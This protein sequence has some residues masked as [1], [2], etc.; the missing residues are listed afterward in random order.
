[1][2]MG[3]ARLTAD[4]ALRNKLLDG[5][6]EKFER[7]ARAVPNAASTF[8]MWGAALVERGKLTGIRND[9]REGIDRLNTSVSLDPNNP[10]TLYSLAGAYAMMEKKL[11]AVQALKK[12]FEVDLNHQFYRLAPTD[13]DLAGLRDVPQ[14]SDLFSAGTRPDP[15]IYPSPPRD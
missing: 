3:A 15:L 7:S 4:R 13:P 1:V 14:F 9:L 8:S 5:A 6:I 12:C 10:A 11:L 2:L